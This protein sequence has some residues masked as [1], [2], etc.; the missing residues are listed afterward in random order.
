MHNSL[1]SP[2]LPRRNG[3]PVHPLRRG[4]VHGHMLLKLIVRGYFLQPPMRFHDKS[5]L[6]YLIFNVMTNTQCENLLIL[7][8]HTPPVFIFVV[9]KSK[10]EVILKVTGQ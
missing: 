5:V 8:Q 1:M 6:R 4:S 9:S 7:I 3:W 10:P 2:R